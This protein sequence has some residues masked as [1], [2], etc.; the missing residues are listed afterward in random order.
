MITII[1]LHF[2]LEFHVIIAA[3]RHL[4]DLIM[5]SLTQKSHGKIRAEQRE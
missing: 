5:A 3:L 4:A 1:H 2:R